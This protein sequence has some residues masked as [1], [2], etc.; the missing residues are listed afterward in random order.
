MSVLLLAAHAL[1]TTAPTLPAPAEEMASDSG[2]LTALVGG[3]VGVII[4]ALARALGIPTDV[5][6]HNAAIRD[7]DDAL[8]TWVADRNYALEQRSR[9][10]RADVDPN[11]GQRP[12]DGTV[13]D[14]FQAVAVATFNSQAHTA[15]LAIAAERTAALHEYRDEERRAS[16]DRAMTLTGEGWPHRL[17]RTVSRNQAPELETPA[18]AAPVLDAWRKPSQM[19]G[20]RP[21]LPED[22]TKR[23]LDDALAAVRSTGI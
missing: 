6:A 11:P 21:V 13:E 4:T 18:K 14:T 9:A 12:K 23:T 10:I 5:R 16:L 17:W 22:A 8:A 20:E 3:A 19:S 7:R 1:I 15:D 2:L